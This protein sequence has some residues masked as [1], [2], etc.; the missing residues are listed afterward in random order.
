MR[1]T[2]VLGLAVVASAHANDFAAHFERIKREATPKQLYALMY[3]LPKGGDLHH[4]L[5]LSFH[6]EDLWAGATDP[7]VTKGKR[8]YTRIKLNGC[9]GVTMPPLLFLHINHAAYS[10]L[11]ACGKGEF[12]ALDELSAGE[13]LAWLSA[14]MLDQPGEGRKEFFEV[15]ASRVAGLA[16]DPDLLHDQILRMLRRYKAENIRYVETQTSAR[17][18]RVEAIRT[19]IQR[20]AEETGVNMRLQYVI[21][22]FAPDAEKSV[23]QAARFVAANRNLWVGINLA[24]REDT[25]NGHA[26]RFLETFRNVRRSHS[27]IR[28]SIHAGEMDSPG[29]EV[30]DTLSIGAERI[31][32]GVN[33]ISDLNTMLLMRNGRH[34]IEVNL[35][36]N[37]LLEYTPDLSK[38]PLP[39]YLRFGIPVCLN[40]DDAGAW[41]SQLTDDYFLAV[42]HFNLT[43]KE[44]VEMGRNSLAFSFA[45]PDL[46]AKLLGSYDAGVAE[47]ER[48]YMA[49]NWRMTLDRAQPAISGYARRR[50]GMR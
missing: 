43:W 4:H 33:L 29:P 14:L 12:K 18:E 27:G 42:R 15:V 30:R 24:G 44:I 9:E 16:G 45:E 46:K 34:L 8:F 25:K 10:R 22:R 2:S 50:L 38:H 23:E 3:E 19:A 5:G 7:G 40:T 28:L 13:R 21:L 37:Q 17:P 31:G 47:F 48:K 1:L 26:L 20:G 41:D 6:A 35:V 32:H 11:D 49:D 36:S 39:E